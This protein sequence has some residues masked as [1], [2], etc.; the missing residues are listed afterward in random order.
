MLKSAATT[1]GDVYVSIIPFSKDVNVGA[2]NY[3]ASWIDWTAWDAAN[4]SGGGFAGIV[5]LGGGKYCF[6]GQIWYWNG[7]SLTISAV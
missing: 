4:G 5:D 1:N 2:S 7:S 3:N 6:Q